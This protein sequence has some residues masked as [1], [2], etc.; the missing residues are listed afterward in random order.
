MNSS[1]LLNEA[2]EIEFSLTLRHSF[3]VFVSACHI[4][5]SIW[6]IKKS[7][8]SI[9]QLYSSKRLH[10]YFTR[11]WVF[12][13]TFATQWALGITSVVIQQAQF[14][15]LRLWYLWNCECTRGRFS[16]GFANAKIIYSHSRTWTV[17]ANS[18]LFYGNLCNSFDTKQGNRPNS[19]DNSTGKPS[20]GKR[21]WKLI[22][23]FA[24]HEILLL[25]MKFWTYATY[26]AIF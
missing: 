10:K 5:T 4:T 18:R 20:S 8:R 21:Q 16:H 25:R 23:M 19:N 15:W 2:N 24:L 12:C 1:Q 6:W 26:R 7:E 11:Q 9:I 3:L 13:K 17:A 22:P 14:D